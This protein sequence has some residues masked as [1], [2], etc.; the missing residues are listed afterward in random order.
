MSRSPVAFPVFDCAS[1]SV[2]IGSTTSG[3]V[4]VRLTAVVSKVRLFAL[5]LVAPPVPIVTFWK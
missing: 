3:P 1:Q 5:M 4:P 2:P